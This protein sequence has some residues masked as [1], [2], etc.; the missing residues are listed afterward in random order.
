[1]S[2]ELLRTLQVVDMLILSGDGI[3]RLRLAA[4][5]RTRLEE[6]SHADADHP[7]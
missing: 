6:L 2:A 1:M 4:W 7:Q 3:N 5:P